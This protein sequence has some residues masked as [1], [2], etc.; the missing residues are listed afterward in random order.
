MNWIIF[1]LKQFRKSN[2]RYVFLTLLLFA[3][4]FSI[5]VSMI[6]AASLVKIH[7]VL[8]G[9]MAEKE[10]RICHLPEQMKRT[11]TGAIQEKNVISQDTT[12]SSKYVSTASTQG[13]YS[14]ILTIGQT[15]FQLGPFYRSGITGWSWWDTDGY[16]AEKQKNL[17]ELLILDNTT[18]TIKPLTGL[19]SRPSWPQASY[20]KHNGN[21]SFK[22]D[23]AP[24]PI[25]AR[26]NYP[27]LID[28]WMIKKVNLEG[29]SNANLTFW[30]WYAMETDYDYGYVAISLDGKKWTNIPGTL[31]TTD[32]PYGNNLGNGITG[33]INGQWVQETMNLTPFTGNKILLGFRFRSDQEANDEGWYVDD[34]SVT[35]GINNLFNDDAE[36]PAAINILSVNVTYP[37]LTLL[38]YAD[39]LT[40]ATTL[41]YGESMQQV[42]VQEDIIHPGTYQGYFLYDPFGEQYS[43]NYSVTL[44]TIINGSQVT[45]STQFQTTVFGCQ[46]CH[47]KKDSG[48]ETSFIHGESG[49]GGSESCMSLCHSGSRGFY[50]GSPP[51]MGPPNSSNPMHVHEM[52]YGHD[53]G[54][55]PGIYYPQLPYT[56]K[57]HVNSTTCQQC[58]TNFLHDNTGTD[59]VKIGSYSLYGTN[60]SFSSGTHQNLTC[61]YCH[62]TLDYPEIP[63]SQYQ[64]GGRLGNYSPTFTSHKSFTDTYIIAVNGTDDLNITVTGENTDGII[65]LTSTGP[66]DNIRTGLQGPCWDEF[67]E[68]IQ[69]LE[70]P[71]YMNITDP[72]IGTWIVNLIQMQGETINYSISSNYPIQKK[73]IIQIPECNTCHNPGGSGKAFT[74]ELILDWDGFA[75]VD[76][77]LDAIGDIQCRM[78]HDPMHDIK[79]K[80]CRVCHARAPIGHPVSDPS[81]SYYTWEQCLSCHGD[82]HIVTGIPDFGNINGTIIDNYGSVV[83]G[84][85]ITTGTGISTMSDLNGAYDLILAP[86]TYQ[87]TTARGFEHYINSSVFVDVTTSSTVTQDI[88][89]ALKP[90][91]NISGTVKNK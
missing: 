42:N 46:G 34:I 50:G 62:G 59:T 64:S 18:G 86:D 60:I 72:Y 37:H 30:T 48:S 53:G 9:D 65:E 79:I 7:D 69:S 76:T 73:P 22:A 32:N 84:A 71:I 23:T 45:A 33:K 90:T 47:N 80:N 77:N 43:G 49:N 12:Y 14:A 36:T 74:N 51:Y 28:I 35:S 85:V 83:S 31:T 21:Y 87:L 66:V 25:T 68:I 17:I 40:S 8:S 55:I 16:G 3:A 29:Y 24:S 39:P 61:E 44:D 67:C 54:F 20:R 70:L 58:H 6:H 82:P 2:L 91:G 75:H 41:Q 26:S 13:N 15:P 78:C 57:A 56:K 1:T 38:N 27:N 19:A 11:E 89:L 81:F 4:F 52:K 10:C 5:N 63:P 88:I